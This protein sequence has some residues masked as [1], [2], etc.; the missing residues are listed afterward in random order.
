MDNSKNNQSQ[1][2]QQQ[3]QPPV[4]PMPQPVP[5][6]PT[7]GMP[8]QMPPKKKM[9]KG[10][11]WGIIG[12]SIGL[13]VLIVGIVLAVIFL[14][15]P[16]KADYQ[17]AQE[18][19]NSIITKY[20]K[21]SSSLSYVSTSETKSSLESNHDKITTAKGDINKALTD[22]GKMKAVTNDKEVR[23]KYDNI[24]NRLEKFNEVMDA[25]G[26]VY[27]KLLPAMSE[28]A[29]TSSSYNI[30]NLATS[31]KKTKQDLKN[32][33]I[34]HEYNKKFVK[35]F[36]EQLEKMEEML[37][38]IIEMRSDYKKYDSSYMTE[39]YT[40]N[41]KIQ[42]IAREWQSNMQKIGEEGELRSE[43]NSLE[44]ILVD[45]VNK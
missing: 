10:A 42:K 8:Y 25:L 14:G 32:A 4:V 45:K 12:G 2:A 6:Q 19:M 44:D 36:T 41:T 13:I 7:P 18:K 23:E 27:G 30:S 11:L 31:I 29:S 43:L 21:V 5:P 26:E 33:D 24:K 37:P 3:V 34:K 28:Y 17:A 9:S 39:F 22:L 20:N 40:I 35:D 1:S 16:S 38:K 15:G